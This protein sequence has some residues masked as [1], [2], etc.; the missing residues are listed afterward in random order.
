MLFYEQQYL[1]DVHITPLM[2]WQLHFWV[3]VNLALLNF[4]SFSYTK[5]WF[6]FVWQTE[7]SFSIPRKRKCRCPSSF[8]RKSQFTSLVS[9]N[10][11][12]R[13]IFTKHA[14]LLHVKLYTVTMWNAILRNDTKQSINM[15]LQ[16][17]CL[18]TIISL[19]NI[20]P[21]I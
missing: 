21:P 18:D 1:L 12:K 4:L 3:F 5:N 14:P 7:N 6:I 9:S 11:V 17:F 10:G 8:A 16:Y 2:S 15:N 13:H 20:I 19:P